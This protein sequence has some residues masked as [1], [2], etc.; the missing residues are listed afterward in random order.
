MEAIKI[1]HTNGTQFGYQVIKN[2]KVLHFAW[3]D[4][5]ELRDKLVDIINTPRLIDKR[6]K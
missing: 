4:T 2:N 1:N 3:V 5:L 6:S